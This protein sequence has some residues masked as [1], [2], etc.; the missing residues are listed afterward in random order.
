[1]TT[2]AGAEGL[3]HRPGV[4]VRTAGS[5]AAGVDS[6]NGRNQWE[7][8]SGG[9]GRFLHLPAVLAPELRD[10]EILPRAGGL[11]TKAAEAIAE[12]DRRGRDH[13]EEVLLRDLQLPRIC[14]GLEGLLLK[15]GARSSHETGN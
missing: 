5:Q 8:A 13:R 1:V 7:R 11:R 14:K 12:R 10:R 6:Q 9:P 4:S 15:D 3:K 2:A